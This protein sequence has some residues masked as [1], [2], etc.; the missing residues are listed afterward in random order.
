[1][2][3]V[4][5]VLWTA[6]T[7]EETVTLAPWPQASGVRDDADSSASDRISAVQHLVTEIRRFR[8]DQGLPPG[9]RVPADI[10]GL[11]AAGIATL[12]P[13]VDTLARLDAKGDD[14]TATATLEVRVGP[15]TVRVA[16]D[17]SG[18]VDVEAE[19]RRLTKDLAAAEKE[20]DQTRGKLDNEQFLAKAPDHVVARIRERNDLALAEI[21]RLGAALAALGGS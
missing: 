4:T 14:F 18:T 20:R 6:L 5:E 17:T 1:M 21:D 13:Y 9:K 3:F 16:V 15:Q 12:A 11:D 7:D 2:P 8:S 19:K 10:G